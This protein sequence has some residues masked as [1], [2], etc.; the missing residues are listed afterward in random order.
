MTGSNGTAMMPKRFS[1]FLVEDEVNPYNIYKVFDEI[2]GSPGN[3]LMENARSVFSA[4][5]K[6][7]YKLKH[8]IKSTLY[9]FDVRLQE[10]ENK[11]E[12]DLCFN[13]NG[14]R[15]ELNR[16]YGVDGFT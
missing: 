13:D 9:I 15:E 6:L 10:K 5:V 7:N 14:F 2:F 16:F 12:F 1:F 8:D 11:A 4:I 3:Y